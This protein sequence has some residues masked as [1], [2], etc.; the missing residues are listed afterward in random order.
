MPQAADRAPLLMIAVDRTTSTPMHRQVFDQIRE[1]ILGGRLAP[2][3]R[4]PSSRALADEIGV[5]RNT[6]LAAYDQLFAEGYTEGQVGSGTTV[7]RVLPEEVLAARAA[8]RP[9]VGGEGAGLSNAGRALLGSKPRVDRST[10]SSIFRPG[11]PEISRFPWNHWSRMVAKFWR[12]PPRHLVSYGEP[13]GY[14]PLRVAIA[15]YL[16]AVRGLACEAE[17]VIVTAGAQQAIDLAARALLDRGDKVWIEEPGYAGIK[18]VLTAAGAELVP[19]PV[20]QDGLVV[21]AGRGLAPN[22]R[23]A[24]VTPSHQYPLGSV[25]SLARRLDLLEWAT[26]HNAWIL[27][28][29]YDSE[30]R[31]S[32]R[33]LSALQG[34]D[35]S[36][37]V[38]YVGTFSKVLF[39]AIR[40]GYMVVPPGL[41][42]PMIRIRRSLD[43]QTAISMQPV[44]SEFIETGHFAGHIRRMRTLYAERQ[45]VLI[46]EISRR[47][48]GVLDVA[49][50]EAGMHL[51]ARIRTV[52]GLSDAD[53]ATRAAAQNL[54]VYPLSEFYIGQPIQNG[55]VLG[56]AGTEE[57]DICAGV[58]RLARLLK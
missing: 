5:S 7:S 40:L 18:G 14:M 53:I 42:E 56:Y 49:P 52:C 39:P 1:A 41:A 22:A 57:R 58:E 51:V 21:S 10:S 31:Y 48:S 9:P 44:L 8:K 2:G 4:L 3:R 30:Y 35:T 20:D 33:P 11:L 16:R 13:G 50:D 37:R 43:D 47:L 29:D 54:T 26:E 25:M 32:G 28:D 36:G 15:D 23:M 38:I 17:Q 45:S 34:L 27:E 24:V 12:K 55:L 19:V 6:V 46:N